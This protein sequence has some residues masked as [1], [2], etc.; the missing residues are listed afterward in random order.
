MTCY[1]WSFDVRHKWSKALD[2]ASEKPGS[3]ILFYV[4]KANMP[5]HG[6]CGMVSYSEIYYPLADFPDAEI[7]RAIMGRKMERK[8]EYWGEDLLTCFAFT[9]KDDKL[10]FVYSAVNP[11]SISW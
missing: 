9:I 10:V 4:C 8:K 5:F 11:M 3:T 1:Q 6:A 2:Y 7:V